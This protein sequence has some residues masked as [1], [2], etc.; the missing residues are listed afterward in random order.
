MNAITAAVTIAMRPQPIA[1]SDDPL[2][3][4]GLGEDGADDESEGDVV[5]AA[6][7]RT[8]SLPSAEIAV[9]VV[10]NSPLA[11]K[12]PLASDNR[13]SP[14]RHG[15]LPAAAAGVRARSDNPSAPTARSARRIIR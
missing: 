3:G 14:T 8:N 7:V 12:R 10:V 6:E 13:G 4:A 2:P 5:G 1:E 11:S 9:P 15:R